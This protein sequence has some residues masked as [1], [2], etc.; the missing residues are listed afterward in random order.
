MGCPEQRV[1]HRPP[2]RAW[3]GSCKHAGQHTNCPTSLRALREHDWLVAGLWQY[4]RLRAPFYTPFSIS[5]DRNRAS[6]PVSQ[7]PSIPGPFSC[8]PCHRYGISCRLH[9]ARRPRPFVPT[10]QYPSIPVSQYPFSCAPYSSLIPRLSPLIHSPLPVIDTGS[11]LGSSIACPLPGC[12]IPSQH[13]RKKVYS[14][15]DLREYRALPA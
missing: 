1:G 15:R 11:G 8:A 6:S 13:G 4:V 2:E 14:A 3:R 9:P 5:P 12:L 10:S 7:H